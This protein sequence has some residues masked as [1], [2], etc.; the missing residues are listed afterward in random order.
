LLLVPAGCLKAQLTPP[1]TSALGMSG[2]YSA[3]ARGFTALAANPANLGLPENPGWSLSIPFLA[4]RQGLSPITLGDINRY[5]GEDIPDSTKEVWLREIEEAGGEDGLGGVEVTGLALSVGPVALQVHSQ[6]FGDARLNPDAAEVL[7]F[8]N[9]GRTGLPTDLDFDGSELDAGVT[10]TIAAGF[11]FPVARRLLGREGTLSL[12]ASLGL[13]FGNAVVLARD[14]G[15]FVA[16]DPIEGEIAFPAI[17]TD[18]DRYRF[19]GGWG[20]GLDLGAAWADER[21]S[22]GLAIDNLLHSFSWDQDALTYRPYEVIFDED[23]WTSDTDKR[24]VGEAP[25]DLLAEL[26]RLEFAPVLTLGG[27]V[28]ARPDLTVAAD[29]RRRF[30]EGFPAGP[31]TR[32]GLGADWRPLTWGSIQS[33]ISYVSEGW[34]VS[35]GASIRMGVVHLGFAYQ[36]QRQSG[37][38]AHL[39]AAGLSFHAR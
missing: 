29:L 5:S 37:T 15:G 17:H 35:A 18:S 1:S 23:G 38:D 8:G 2:N 9:S 25:P 6:G 36:H 21:W 7:L 20:L 14:A 10:T 12:G 27:A 11:G 26:E 30:R 32:I 19:N 22:L 13:A 33:G 34:G 24:P 31:A 16:S 4:V 28:L 3:V 39:M